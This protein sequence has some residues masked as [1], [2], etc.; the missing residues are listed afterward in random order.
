MCLSKPK[1][2]AVIRAPAQ[3]VPESETVLAA[4]EE[5]MR[6]RRRA[7]GLQSTLLTG[8]S[9]VTSVTGGTKTLL[10]Q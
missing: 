1:A 8:G 4:R 2:P 6:R 9:G 7:S 5:E 3:P 10:G